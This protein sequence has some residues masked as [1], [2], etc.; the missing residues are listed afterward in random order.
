MTLSQD[1]FTLKQFLALP[2]DDAASELI[3]GRAV[4]KMSPKFFHSRLQKTL[5]FIL[6]EWSEGTG[7][8]EPEWGIILRRNGLDWVPV[9]DL[10]YVSFERL[11]PEW[12]KDEACPVPPELVIEIISPGQTFGEM[13]EKA[14]DYLKAG[15]ER[16]WVVD[17][18]SQ[19]ITIFSPAAT[20]QTFRGE[21]TIT[22]PILPHLTLTPQGIFNRSRIK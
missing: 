16:V 21:M 20:P 1:Y 8:V 3:E 14:T 13:T 22:D 11:P 7:R 2:V 17:S 6:E 19:R 4:P 12:M 18:S 10:T 5:L 9:P 15:V